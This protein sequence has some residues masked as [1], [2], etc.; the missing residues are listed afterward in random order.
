MYFSQL[1]ISGATEK[2]SLEDKM[3]ISLPFSWINALKQ[4]FVFGF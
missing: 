1:I 2:L 3:H 4:L